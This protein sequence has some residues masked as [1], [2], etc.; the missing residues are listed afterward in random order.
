MALGK[1]QL[2]WGSRDDQV[3]D[4]PRLGSVLLALAYPL[5]NAMAEA[6]V[7]IFKRDYAY[8]QDYPDAQTV[9]SHL[10]TW[11]EDYDEFH[12]SQRPV[13]EITA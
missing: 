5:S 8:V 11:F 2:L 1:W 13:N 9:L 3:G 12:P 10:Y 6:F 4:P 7:K